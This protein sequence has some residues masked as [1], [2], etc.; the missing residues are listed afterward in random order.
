VD[1]LFLPTKM[2]TNKF[3]LTLARTIDHRVGVTD[4]CKPDVPVL[5][6]NYALASFILR[7][8]IVLVNFITCAFVIVNIIHHW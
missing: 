1:F 7:F 4:E 6:V 3:F 2:T 5:P 8:T